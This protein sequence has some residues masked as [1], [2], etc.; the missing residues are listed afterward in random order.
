[1][2]ASNRSKKS[3]LNFEI[4]QNNGNFYRQNSLRTELNITLPTLKA[5]NRL[6]LISKGV[7]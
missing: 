5:V 1:M 6:P 4:Q 3:F 7:A 2:N